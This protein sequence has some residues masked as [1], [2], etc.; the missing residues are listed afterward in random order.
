[1][2]EAVKISSEERKKFVSLRGLELWPF[3]K[4]LYQVKENED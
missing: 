1:M 4:R 2:V 3:P